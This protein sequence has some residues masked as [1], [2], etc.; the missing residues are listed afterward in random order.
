MVL[1]SYIKHRTLTYY[2]VLT[3]RGMKFS[4]HGK[5]LAKQIGC[6]GFTTRG[7]ETWFNEKKATIECVGIPGY[8]GSSSP[9]VAG[10]IRFAKA[11]MTRTKV[12]YVHG[13][14]LKA[15]GS[16]PRVICQLVNDQARLWGGGVARSA[17]KAF[18]KAQR[19]FSNWIVSVPKSRRLGDVHFAHAENNIYIASLVGQ[20]VIRPAILV[21]THV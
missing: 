17:A 12:N 20:D 15:Q 3:P 14:V 7:V 1:P 10:L 21:L 8:P 19:E 9:R 4:E 5:R 2:V 18:P 11:E 13:N 16:E 6:L